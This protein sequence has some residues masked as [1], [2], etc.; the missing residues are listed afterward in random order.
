MQVE[1]LASPS[2]SFAT[3]TIAPGGE[4]QVEAGAMAAYTDGVQVE[5]SA[6]GGIMAGLKRSVLGG[7]SFFINTFTAPAGGSVSVAPS[8]PG[9]MATV[10]LDGSQALYV[11]SG[12]WIASDPT[13]DVDTKWGGSKTFF[14]GEGLFLLR[15]TGQGDL[16]MSSYGAIL[17]RTLGPGEGYTLD[18]GHIVAFDD[19]V[20]YTVQK[21]GNWK[22]TMLGGEGLVTRLVGPGRLWLQTRSPS[23]LLA[24]LIPQLPTQTN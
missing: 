23:D 20:Q 12:S 9:D 13:I 21:A 1:I 22:T 18:T 8:L 4:V 11:Q 15:C 5:T 19:T 24:W 16:L 3:L 6:R 7:E 2:F 17:S 14:S 10:S